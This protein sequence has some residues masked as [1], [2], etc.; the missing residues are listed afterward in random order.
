[1]EK[2]KFNDVEWGS[3]EAKDD[4]LLPTYFVK[5][6]E[7]EGILEGNYRYV[8]GRKGSGKT[9]MVEMIKNEMSENPLVFHKYVS[10]KNFPLQILKSMR[11]K[12]MED[13]S[14]YVKIWKYLILNDLASLIL[15]DNG[16]ENVDLITSLRNYIQLNFPDGI[17]MADSLEYLKSNSAKLNLGNEFLVLQ[18][19]VLMELT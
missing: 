17:T 11:D 5:I 18:L 10:L 14:Q 3:D 13:K 7:Y 19:K 1:M 2:I 6:P 12:G 4:N 16:I 8:I 15:N 9:A